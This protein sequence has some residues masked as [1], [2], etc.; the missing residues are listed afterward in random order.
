MKVTSILSVLILCLSLTTLAGS[1]T[2][3]HEYYNYTIWDFINGRKM[4]LS[5]CFTTISVKDTTDIFTW[6]PNNL[7][8]N[9][10]CGV[11]NCAFTMSGLNFKLGAC[12]GNATSP[13]TGYISRIKTATRISLVSN[14]INFFNGSNPAPVFVL[15]NIK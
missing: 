2:L 14:L 10:P 5:P 13:C 7:N 4:Y 8:I 1:V 11:E 15:E 3:S 9:G 6:Q 12:T